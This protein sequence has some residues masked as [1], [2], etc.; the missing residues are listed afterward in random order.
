MTTRNSDKALE[1]TKLNPRDAGVADEMHRVFQRSYRKE[2]E[3]VGVEDFP[4][5]RRT[6]QDLQDSTTEF[7]GCRIDGELAAVVEVEGK[8][9][10]LDICSMVVDPAFFRRGL[11]SRLLK[12]L[13]ALPLWETAV[14]ETAVANAPAI[15][16]YEKLGFVEERR[17]Q[18][19]QGI[20][21]LSL[22]RQAR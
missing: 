21:K 15:A 8:G 9:R 4:P 17:W 3:L 1:L 22:R 16:L 12:H 20:Q 7:Y 10:E 11:A 18:I 5:L 2:A 6:S 19:E 14:V 13:L